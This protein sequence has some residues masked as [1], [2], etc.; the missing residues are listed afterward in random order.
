MPQ[1]MLTKMW[2]MQRTLNRFTFKKNCLRDYD[3][4]A[5]DP[6]RQDEWV[7]N[8]TLAMRQECAELMDSTNWKWWRTKVERFDP[9][10]IAVELVD[11]LHFWMS[12]CQ[13]M[14]MTPESVF[15]A[16]MEKNKVNVERQE[17][18]Y[19]KKD[20]DDCKHIGVSP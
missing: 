18:G 6:E 4:I 10:N 17:S 7:Q 9:Q 2:E 16:Y 12:A 20:E 11:I 15:E 8:Y 13:V 14:G 3:A 1:D 5:G 19:I